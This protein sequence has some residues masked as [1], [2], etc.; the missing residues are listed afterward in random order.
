MRICFRKDLRLRPVFSGDTKFSREKTSWREDLVMNIVLPSSHAGE[1][2][3]SIV[4]T[5]VHTVSG[6][7]KK[8][9]VDHTKVKSKSQWAKFK[10]MAW[11]S[12]IQHTATE[13]KKIGAIP[14]ALT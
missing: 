14:M 6:A 2:N 11:E 10:A 13:A 5:V 8:G 3:A 9:G 12:A 4:A 1:A 7:F